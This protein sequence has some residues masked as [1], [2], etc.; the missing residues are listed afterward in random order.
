MYR[1]KCGSNKATQMHEA[2]SSPVNGCL[3]LDRPQIFPFNQSAFR[4][5]LPL[6]PVLQF[7]LGWW[8]GINFALTHLHMLSSCWLLQSFSLLTGLF[9]SS[10]KSIQRD[11]KQKWWFWVQKLTMQILVTVFLLSGIIAPLGKAKANKSLDTVG[12]QLKA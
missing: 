1:E 8:T 4:L 11:Q 3:I 9:Y 5:L 2:V 7:I 6:L 10:F 12:L